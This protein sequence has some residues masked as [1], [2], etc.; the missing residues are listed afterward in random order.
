MDEFIY[1]EMMVHPT[2]V[3]LARPERVLI[4][5]GGGAHDGWPFVQKA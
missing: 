5:G 1:H 4:V 3:S 2:L